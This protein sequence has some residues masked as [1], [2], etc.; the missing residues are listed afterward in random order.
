M[1]SATVSSWQYSRKLFYPV[2]KSVAVI[3]EVATSVCKA[4][5]GSSPSPNLGKREF[6]RAC[7]LD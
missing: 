6:V 1:T 5:T 4:L 3:A 2:L 7:A